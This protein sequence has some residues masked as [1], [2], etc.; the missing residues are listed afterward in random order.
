MTSPS[1]VHLHVH[2]DY[3]ML[4]GACRVKDLVAQAL[5]CGMPALAVTDHGNMCAAVEFHEACKAGGIRPIIGCECYVAPG[6]HLERNPRD[7]FAQGFHLVL[8]AQD[9]AG[10]TNLCRLNSIAWHAG[11]YYKPRVDKDLLARHSQG[12]IALSACIGGEI[13]AMLLKADAK[14]AAA[15]LQQYRDIFGPDRFFLELQDHGMPEE[16][17]ANRGLLELA[18]GHGVPLVATNDI[19]YLKQEHASA[20]DVLL[21]IGTATTLTDAS[22]IRF[23]SNQFYF[24]SP[25]EMAS[26][27]AFCPEALANTGAIAERCTFELPLGE[28]AE[29]HYPVYAAPD[30]ISREAFIRRLCLQGLRERYGIDAE[31]PDALS[32]E[33]RTTL[34]RMDYELGV[35][36]KSGFISYYLVVWDFLHFARQ[37][38]I[39][40]GPGRGSGAGSLVAYLLRITDIDPLRYGLLF[41]RFLNPDRVSPPDFDIDLCEERRHEVIAYVRSKYGDD[42]VAQ[43][44]TFGTLKA[45]AVLKDV[46]RVT[47]RSFAESNQLTKLVPEDPKMTLAKALEESAELRDLVEKEAWVQ[48]I[49]NYS[50]VLEGLNRNYSIHAAGV[51]IGDQPLSTLVPLGRGAGDEVITQYPMAACESLGLLKMDFLGLS[52]LTILADA[53]KR[54]EKSRGIRLDLDTAPLDDRKTFELLNRGDTVAV[55][56]LE[57]GGMRDLCRRFGMNRIEDIIALIALYRP[58]PMQFLDEFISRKMGQTPIDYDVPEMEP[59]LAETYGIMLY[60]EQVMQ[61]VQRVAGFTLGQADILRRAMGKKKA[62]VMEKQYARFVDGCVANGIARERADAIWEKIQKFAGYG[63]NKSHSAA[64]ALLSYR[65]A[66]LKANYPV[67]FMAAV[68]TNQLGNSDKLAFFLQECRGMGI[69]VQPPDVSVSERTFTVDGSAI[70]FGLAAIKGVGDAAADAIAEARAGQPFRSLLDFCERAGPKLNRRVIECLCK[71]GACDGFGLHR[72]QLLEMLDPVLTSAL[73]VAADRSRGQGFFD[74]AGG[75]AAEPASDLAPPDIPEWP[76][77]QRLLFEKELLGVYVTGHPLREWE[78]QIRTFQSAGAAELADLDADAP[79]RLGGLLAG[80][81]IKRTRKEQR[82]MAVVQIEGL[83]GT[84]ECVFFPD[85]FERC[86]PLLVPESVVFVEGSVNKREDEVKLQ[87]ERVVAVD[88]AHELFTAELH[89]RIPEKLAGD[90]RLREFQALCARTPGATPV[91]LCLLCSSG[92]IAFVRPGNGFG[93]RPSRAFIDQVTD[94]FGQ[95]AILAKASRPESRPRGGNG[96]RP[97]PEQAGATETEAGG[98]EHDAA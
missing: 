54:I 7:E 94:L 8:L 35:I 89:V 11:H 90:G 91:L 33:G 29:N 2:T 85:A 48:D 65:T 16:A 75:P 3:S 23:H 36:G 72:A 71:A 1:F 58:G 62:D 49:L 37:Q 17:E 61:V 6:S 18:K 63:F 84:V 79:V 69:A 38:G 50:R 28:R 52:T 60:Q 53:V 15:A 81:D 64:Y 19:H 95:D 47:G 26:L 70:R 57:S 44:G 83:T 30:G 67:E 25:A 32:A 43:I 78:A 68:L 80:V 73:Q 88:D 86:E 5:E 74:F 4:D 39:P 66:Y 46:A 82:K 21:C 51:I 12:L 77:R 56:Q 20:H 40:V 14:R 31:R 93:V 55:F 76:Q 34:A 59:I 98:P 41:E 9:S 97:P 24:K 13:P 42:S 45:K 27:F 87:G 92:D 22:R 10:Y 96:R